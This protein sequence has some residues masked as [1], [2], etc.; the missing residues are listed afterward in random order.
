MGLVIV[1]VLIVFISIFALPFILKEKSK[2]LDDNYMQ[3]ISNNLRSV[4][5]NTNICSAATVKDE[6]LNCEIGF[7]TCLTC[8]ELEGVIRN[9]IENSLG[10]SLGNI[11]YNFIAGN[12][13]VKKGDCVEKIVSSKSFIDEIDVKVELCY[14]R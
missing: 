5:L 8:T 4:V 9:I 12:L 1:V 13:E 14:R 3:L 2:T 6:L 7:P 10:D 11:N